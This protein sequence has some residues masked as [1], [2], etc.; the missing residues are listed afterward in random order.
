[1]A[2][3]YALPEMPKRPGNVAGGNNDA[4]FR[5][6]PLNPFG[7]PKSN[8]SA[9]QMRV[10]DRTSRTE[11]QYL[12]D[13]MKSE[14]DFGMAMYGP[15]IYTGKVMIGTGRVG[16]V[17]DIVDTLNRL[18]KDNLTEVVF[19]QLLPKIIEVG[20]GKLVEKIPLLKGSEGVIADVAEDAIREGGARLSDMWRARREEKEWSKEKDNIQRAVDRSEHR[21]RIKPGDTMET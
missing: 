9:P 6:T 1:M 10:D 12:R 4:R 19:D 3:Y 17:L 20:T 14:Q 21:K 15:L 8:P 5:C 18:R 16:A 13:Q 2:D 7:Q 11:A